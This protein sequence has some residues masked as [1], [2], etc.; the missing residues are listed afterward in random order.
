MLT[1]AC[2]WCGTE[3]QTT[4]EDDVYCSQVCMETAG[5]G[6]EIPTNEQEDAPAR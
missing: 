1:V 4:C 3:Y 2:R 6:E 5:E